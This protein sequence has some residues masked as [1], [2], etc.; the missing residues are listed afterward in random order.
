MEKSEKKSKI[1]RP[2]DVIIGLTSMSHEWDMKKSRR[3][4]RTNGLTAPISGPVLWS[5][6]DSASGTRDVSHEFMGSSV[7]WAFSSLST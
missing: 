4:Y 6:T 2:R 3:L 5:V 1:I 7:P